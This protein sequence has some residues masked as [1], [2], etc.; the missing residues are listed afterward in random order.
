V[1]SQKYYENITEVLRKVNDTQMQN[2]K[3]AG[4]LIAKSLMDGK[5]LHLFGCGHSHMLVEEGFYRAG[6]LAPVN[7]LFD[8][9]V[10][11]HG[12]AIKSSA[13]ERL[14]GYAELI[15]NNYKIDA[16]DAIII[17]SNSGRNELVVDMAACAKKKGMR[18][19]IVYSSSYKDVSSRHPSGK[20]MEAF[21]DIA[22]D[23]CCPYGDS[24]VELPGQDISIAPGST[25]AGAAILNMINVSVAET[26][27][28]EGGELEYFISGNIDGGM[29][30]NNQLLDKY[31]GKIRAL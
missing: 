21:A 14:E 5:I 24:L 4:K 10:M 16:G 22:I 20:R 31:K 12:G 18:V 27:I 6:G 3:A 15:F 13:V 19:I 23:N 7:P 30:R 17:F 11:L 26:L 28:E 1:L 29:E 9:A 25:V 8:S 2:I